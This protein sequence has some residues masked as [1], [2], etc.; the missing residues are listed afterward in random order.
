MVFS[1]LSFL[2]A[3]LPITAVL[4]LICRNRVWRNAVLLAASLFFYSWGEP[5]R[6]VWMILAALLAYVCGILMERCRNRDGLRR[7]IFLAGV[8]LITG[9]LLV[10][11]Y[12]GFF[13]GNLRAL[14]GADWALPEIVLP[15][16]IS[17]YTFQIL[18]YVIDLYRDQVRVQRNFWYL[19]LYVSF[20][21]QLIA[22]P[23]VRYQTV[24]E[25]ITNRR[26]TLPEVA[27]GLKR[28]LVGL[29]KKVLIANQV[30]VI[31]DTI[32]AGDPA[33]FG[34][35]MYWIA[36]LSY[37]LQIYFDFSGYSDMAIGLGR[38]F[39]FHFLENFDHPYIS[40]SITEFWRRWHIS[41]SSW[42]RDY[43]YIPLGGN[44]VSRG[45]WM[46]NILVVW[47]ITGFWHGAD[48][49][50]LLW[51]LYYG[52]LLMLE[53]LFLG[54]WLS[55]L[56][57]AA[58][59]CYTMVLVLVGWVLFYMT[60]LPSLGRALHAM[61]TLPKT[62]WAAVL[63]GHYGL[64]RGLFFLPLGMVCALPWRIPRGR[65]S[66]PRAV[67]EYAVYALLLLL[68]VSTILSTKYNPFIYFRF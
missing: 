17:F 15:I 18:S 42:F 38:M 6:M 56:P 19:L 54:K 22:G 26:E 51:G 64:L 63:T 29:S 1:S 49:N 48:W 68:C 16:G 9:N 21:P 37:A 34:G 65:D 39:G 30:G 57:R 25:E 3:F 47:V 11:K 13:A 23:I 53:K 35:A 12:F 2:Y 41:L 32:Y 43:I 55:R 8:V 31:A 60:D 24:E 40:C 46:R 44:R 36:A 7:G 10:F 33:V 27:A 28:F 14:F 52:V 61:F 58:G 59:W 50:F 4:Y 66:L 5:R 45:K 20:F 62:D 67:A